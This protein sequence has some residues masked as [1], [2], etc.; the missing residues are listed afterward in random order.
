MTAYCLNWFWLNWF[1]EIAFWL[2]ALGF[3]LIYGLK[4][5]TIHEL[6]CDVRLSSLTQRWK[7]GWRQ[8]WGDGTWAWKAHQIWLNFLGS[9]LGWYAFWLFLRECHRSWAWPGIALLVI[10]FLGMTGLIPHVSRYG[11]KLIHDTAPKQ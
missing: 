10:A 2:L 4:S 11:S 1:R 5:W 7:L 6:D 8:L 3:S 9:I